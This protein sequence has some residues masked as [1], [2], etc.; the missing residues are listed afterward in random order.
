MFA[1]VEKITPFLEELNS[2]FKKI[3]LRLKKDID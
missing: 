1:F 2:K 3:M